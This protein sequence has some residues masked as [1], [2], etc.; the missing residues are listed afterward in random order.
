MG[1]NQSERIT[2]I[3]LTFSIIAVIFVL[4]VILLPVFTKPTWHEVA[5]FSGSDNGMLSSFH[6]TSDRWKIHWIASPDTL[7]EHTMCY[8]YVRGDNPPRPDV[9]EFGAPTASDFDDSIFGFVRGTEYITGSGT[10]NIT[11]LSFE[12]SWGIIVEAYY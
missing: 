12:T 3:T 10:F 6:I 1:E 5:E 9:L 2:K 7:S 8:F 4:G 11:V